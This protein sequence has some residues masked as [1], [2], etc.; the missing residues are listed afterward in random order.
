MGKSF[1]QMAMRGR[2]WR[3]L[4]QSRER[5]THP[6]AVAKVA[7][8]KRADRSYIMQ[9]SLG[10]AVFALDTGACRRRGVLRHFGMPCKAPGFSRLD[11]G[12]LYYG[13]RVLL[14]TVAVR[15]LDRE[16]CGFGPKSGPNDRLVRTCLLAALVSMGLVAVAF[17]EFSS[18]WR[19]VMPS[20]HEASLRIADACSVT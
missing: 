17:L 15:S 7:R 9:R 13:F 1:G 14:W 11:H 10:V 4:Q 3:R 5:R 6:R 20:P 12:L 8:I 2:E 19:N 16:L 18:P